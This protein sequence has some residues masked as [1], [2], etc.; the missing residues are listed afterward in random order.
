MKLRYQIPFQDKSFFSIILIWIVTSIIYTIPLF[1]LINKTDYQSITFGTWII[2]IVVI[3][4]SLGVF[5]SI[6]ELVIFREF[7]Y[8]LNSFFSLLLKTILFSFAYLATS[9]IFIII[10]NSLLVF[11]GVEDKIIENELEIFLKTDTLY[12]FGLIIVILSFTINFLLQ[13]K[14][15]LGSKV[16]VNLFFEK[17][18]KP[19]VEKKILMFLDISDSTT[20]AEKIGMYK[21]SSLLQNFFK[22][23]DPAIIKSRGIIYQ[24]VGD[25]VII[26]WDIKDGVDNYNCIKFFFEAKKI[27]DKNRNKYIT[28][29]GVHPEFKAGIH[30]G[31]VIITEVGISKQEITYH[32]DTINTTARI[33]SMCNNFAKNL[34]VSAELLSL[35]PDLDDKFNVE[36]NGVI[37]LKGKK[38]AV[39]LFSIED[40]FAMDV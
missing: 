38:N 16:L 33:R 8:R 31:D 21:F 13:V 32:G 40:R 3:S 25:E 28:K 26:T 35:L 9:V 27:L 7:Q 6:F 39:A 4:F 11:L 10:K 14:S 17:Y 20:I 24:F 34:L 29:Y 5:H 37:Q 23:I 19:K 22:D 36:A 18:K 12:W 30:I 2:F 15:K 1:Y